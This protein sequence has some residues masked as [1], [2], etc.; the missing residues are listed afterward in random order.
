MKKII[1]DKNGIEKAEILIT[2]IKTNIFSGE[3]ISN[4]FNDSEKELFLEFQALVNSQVFSLLDGV[5]RKI[6]SKG[7]KIRGE[8]YPIY[9]LQIW[10]MKTFSFRKD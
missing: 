4:S 5:E 8:A 10:D 7:F 3:I 1:E 6:E 9:D 2:S